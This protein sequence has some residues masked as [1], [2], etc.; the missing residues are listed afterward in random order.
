M[1]AQR[2][3]RPFVYAGLDF[4]FAAAFCTLAALAPNRHAI[5]QFV[6][7]ALPLAA[8]AMG[9]GT[10]LRGR[11]GWRI[12]ITGCAVLLGLELLLLVLLLLSAAFLSGVY[13][14][15][16]RG[17]AALTLLVAALSFEL[18]AL[19]PALQLKYLLGSAGR[20]ALQ[21]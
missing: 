16:G 11:W 14:S 9:A 19:L 2:D 15:F 1:S 21:G 6:L 7:V 3:I 13:G 10:A 18:V 12:A 17:A 20:R 8:L 4:L 5:G